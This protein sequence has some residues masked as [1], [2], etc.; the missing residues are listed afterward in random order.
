MP[1]RMPLVLL[2]GLLCDAALWRHQM[3]NLSDLAEMIVADVTAE[4]QAGPMAQRILA[5]APEEFAL[6]GLS[7]GGYIAFEI[8]R[9]APDRVMRL[10]LLDTTAR[11]D[12]L[13]KTKLRQELIDLAQTGEFKGVTPRL[14]PRL[15]HTDRLQDAKLV[16]SILSMAERIGR[17]AFIRQERLL[18]MR[19]DSRHDLSLI[20]CPTLVLCGRQDGLTPLADSEEMAEKI[21]R[22]KLVVVEDCGHLST[23][24]RPHAV[25]AVLRY[26]LQV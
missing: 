22:A 14:L 1:G 3:E 11:A 9:Q 15:I 26:W 5:D 25:T 17:D 23:M 6:A 20:H 4:D 7:M 12:T 10:A 13:E 19:P 24:E 2:P 21:P 8:L 16:A 18:M